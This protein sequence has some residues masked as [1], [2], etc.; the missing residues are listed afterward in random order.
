MAVWLHKVLLVFFVNGTAKQKTNITK[1]KIGQYEKTQF[2][3]KSVS[4]IN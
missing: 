4:K 1:L 2:Q 3:R